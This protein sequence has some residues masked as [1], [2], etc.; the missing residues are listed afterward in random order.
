M[1]YDGVCNSGHT[2]QPL[3][4]LTTQTIAALTLICALHIGIQDQRLNPGEIFFLF[5][6]LP[7][8]LLEVQAT[9]CDWVQRVGC[10]FWCLKHLQKHKRKGDEQKIKI[11]PGAYYPNISCFASSAIVFELTVM[12][13]GCLCSPAETFT[14][15]Y[16]A[17]IM[18]RK[19]KKTFLFLP[20]AIELGLRWAL[21]A[22]FLTPCHT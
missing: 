11:C 6:L 20:L 4:S 21:K 16:D 15:K 8:Y 7:S 3:C 2:T 19:K 22:P 9:L 1:P 5:V 10:K 17:K 14:G 18:S 13:R 12:T